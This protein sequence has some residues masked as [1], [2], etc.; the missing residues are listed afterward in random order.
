MTINQRVNEFLTFKG[1]SYAEL[2]RMI[3]SKRG[4][5]SS[6]FN[7]KSIVEIPPKKIL[8]IVKVFKDVN[9]RWLITGEGEMLENAH[10]SSMVAEAPASYGD[11]LA[12]LEAK[13]EEVGLLKAK[14]HYLMQ[15]ISQ[16]KGDSYR[17]QQ[18]PKARAG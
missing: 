4:D 13:S 9:A 1:V 12:R 16:L 5:V 18:K 11:C 10:N 14:N 3:I 15:E 2:G 17:G 7:E 8:E 6:W